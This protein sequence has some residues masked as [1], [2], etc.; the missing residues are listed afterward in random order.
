MRCARNP[1]SCTLGG[2]LK[3]GALTHLLRSGDA[4]RTVLSD[5]PRAYVASADPGRDGPGA[6]AASARGHL[7]VPVRSGR[8]GAPQRAHGLRGAPAQAQGAAPPRA[9]RGG[10]DSVDGLVAG[11][12]LL[13]PAAAVLGRGR[14][15]RP[16]PGRGSA[17]AAV[18]RALSLRAVAVRHALRRSCAA[19]RA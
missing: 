6:L 8:A 10:A 2:Y 17:D 15:D 1:P 14:A 13:R 3:C 11:Q 9:R 4:P 18:A 5:A 12:R 16:P 7:A 19:A